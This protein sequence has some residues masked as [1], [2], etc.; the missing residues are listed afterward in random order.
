MLISEQIRSLASMAAIAEAMLFNSC[1]LRSVRCATLIALAAAAGISRFASITESYCANA[2]A[3]KVVEAASASRIRAIQIFA[4]LGN[5]VPWLHP[6]MSLSMGNAIPDQSR[7]D[8]G[9]HA[10]PGAPIGSITKPILCLSAFVSD[11]E[12]VAMRGAPELLN[13][14]AAPH[15]LPYAVGPP[16]HAPQ[17]NRPALEIGG[18]CAS[19]DEGFAPCFVDRVARSTRVSPGL[20]A[21]YLFESW[22]ALRGAPVHFSSCSFAGPVRLVRGRGLAAY[23]S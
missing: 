7:M 4:A 22:P 23:L 21:G 2:S 8:Q 15:S 11:V 17:S 20:L 18:D 10:F 9:A 3:G 12:A 5:S 1:S 14:A 13:A 19:S 16:R 6:A